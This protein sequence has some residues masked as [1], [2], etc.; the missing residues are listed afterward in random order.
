MFFTRVLSTFL[1]ASKTITGSTAAYGL[2]IPLWIGKQCRRI[3]VCGTV[4]SPQPVGK[5]GTLFIVNHPSLIE[6][7]ALPAVLS[8][9]RWDKADTR[10]PY[11]VAD[12]RLFGRHSGWLYEHFRCIPV[13]RH[14][15]SSARKSWRTART[16]LHIL[17]TNGQ[18]IVYPEGGRTCKGTQWHQ[19]GQKMVRSC[20]PTIVKMAQRTNATIIPVWISHGD[21][22]KPQSLLQ[23]YYK[24]FFKKK[25]VITFGSPVTFSSLEVTDLEVANALLQTAIASKS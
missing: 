21:S 9:W 2:L 14:E 16:C 1:S 12:S 18:L 8:P 20:N 15:L 6:T 13:H 17:T 3:E 4:P 5:K 24:L 7:I 10:L 22:T 19:Q 25:L 11:S 23:G